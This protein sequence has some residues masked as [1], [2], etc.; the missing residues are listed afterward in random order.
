MKSDFCVL[1]LS[2]GRPDN[3]V[4][5]NTLKRFGYTG[6]WFIVLDDLDPTIDK[7]KKNFGDEH[8]V[9]FNKSVYMNST[10]SMDNF[11]FH[12][13][14]VYARNACIDI[15]K[16]LGYR[17]FAEFEDDYDSVRWRMNPQ[18]EYSSKMIA[19]NNNS[20]DKIFE[21]MLDYLK[22]TPRITSIAMAQSGDYI[23]GG[24][25]KMAVDQFRRKEMNSWLIDTERPFSFAGTM[26]DDVNVYTTLTS[27]G[28]LFLTTGFVAINQK[29][30]QS[31]NSGNTDMYKKF[32]TYVKSFYSVVGHP[33]GVRIGVLHNRGDRVSTNEFRV[34]HT[35]KWK[36]VAP[37]ILSEKIK[38]RK[39]P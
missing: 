39:K 7:Y 3:V 9:V 16:G 4:T 2:H 35:V 13:S 6:Y 24:Q 33:S 30:T 25:S 27:Q 10:D 36:N 5:V 14:I 23:G 28:T 31:N 34:H 1:I 19:E 32:G 15:A 18:I 21:V 20:L 17:Y 12:K 29:Q 26:N 8:V 37:L 38:K 22:N 11:Q